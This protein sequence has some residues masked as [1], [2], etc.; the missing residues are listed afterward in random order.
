M[1]EVFGLSFRMTMDSRLISPTQI[2]LEL[3]L[4]WIDGG[5]TPPTYSVALAGSV[6]LMVVPPPE[7]DNSP[8][9]IILTR[10]PTT[11]AVTLMDTV[12]DPGVDP[13]C[14]GTVP[15]LSTKVVVPGTAVTVPPQVLMTPAGSSITMPGCSRTKL[16]VQ[17]AFVNG[18]ALGL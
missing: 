9:G 4:F 11:V 7:D 5:S 2:V 18:N 17:D 3:K 13:L 12:Q 1:S 16:S 6:L 10:F 14:A 8:A 15:P